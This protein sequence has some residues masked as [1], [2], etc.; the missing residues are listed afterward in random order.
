MTLANLL[1]SLVGPMVM[2]A[3][4]LLG[5]GMITFTGVTTAL[6]SLIDLATSNW[7]SLAVDVLALASVAGLPQAV[8]IITG[9]MTARV[10]MWAAVSATKWVLSPAS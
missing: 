5:I 8:G 3:L 4:T 10:G 7:S 6:Q 2:R 9:A 1:M